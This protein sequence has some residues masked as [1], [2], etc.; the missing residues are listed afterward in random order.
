MLI[1]ISRWTGHDINEPTGNFTLIDLP[2]PA[3][4]DANSDV[5][6]VGS[7]ALFSCGLSGVNFISPC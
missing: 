5:N 6:A 4:L 2:M 3:D 1:D 7:N